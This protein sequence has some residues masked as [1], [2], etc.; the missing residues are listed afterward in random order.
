MAKATKAAAPAA[1][2]QRAA[3]LEVLDPSEQS[4]ALVE[5]KENG[6]GIIAWL[7][8]LAPF[9]RTATQLETQ[10]KAT[11]ATAKALTLPKNGSD[12]ETLQ[13]FIV[14]AREDYKRVTTH[15][16]ITAKISKF[17]KT[18]TAA[19]ARATDPLEE[20]GTIATTLHNR[21]VAAEKARAEEENR[22]REAEAAR[23]QQALRD[24]ELADIEAAAIAEETKSEKLSL[25]EGMF[26]EN[27]LRTGNALAAARY[28]GFRNP[29]VEA[30]RLVASKKI[31]D[32]IEGK[33][34]AEE[35][36][37]QA[38]ATATKPLDPVYIEEVRPDLGRAG[39]DVNTYSAEITDVDAFR[40]AVIDGKLGIPL[41]TL[42]PDQVRLNICARD[43][44]ELIDRWPGIRLKKKTGVR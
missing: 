17:H 5:T 30:P 11:L 4:T 12:D 28:A 2:R 40:R 27:Y 14:R 26:L 32:A 16:D 37:K 8:S 31:I 33:R 10:S 21:Y 3:E 6:E 23:K 29:A 20:A 15:W 35:L 13:R 24:Q 18:L 22:K 34:A 43:Y 41:D 36:R 39:S 9:F 19:R 25:R 38:T 44:K 42:I 1:N 7:A